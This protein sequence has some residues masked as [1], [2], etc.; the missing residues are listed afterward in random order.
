MKQVLAAVLITGALLAGCGNSTPSASPRISSDIA[1]LRFRT[2]LLPTG[3]SAYTPGV[4]ANELTA[5][6]NLVWKFLGLTPASYE[7]PA[8]AKLVGSTYNPRYLR[9]QRAGGELMR[10][11]LVQLAPGQVIPPQVTNYVDACRALHLT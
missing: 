5:C 2:Q 9:F 7:L 6:Q 11:G 4:S 1:W 10:L 3:W 8:I